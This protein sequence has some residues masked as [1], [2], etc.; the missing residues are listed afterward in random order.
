[1][2]AFV[3]HEPTSHVPPHNEDAIAQRKADHAGTQQSGRERG[4]AQR[5]LLG[6]WKSVNE[7][8]S[9]S[10][11]VLNSYPRSQSQ[12]RRVQRLTRLL[13]ALGLLLRPGDGGW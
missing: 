4:L 11:G 5:W 10:L 6:Q 7:L 3:R 8:S 1:M 13:R 12:S 2:A 9:D